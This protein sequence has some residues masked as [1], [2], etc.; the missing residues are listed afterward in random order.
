MN[1]LDVLPGKWESERRRIL[2]FRI[3]IIYRFQKDGKAY[4]TIKF[5]NWIYQAAWSAI[6][7]EWYADWGLASERGKIKLSPRGGTSYPT[8]LIDQFLRTIGIRI[9]Y[10]EFISSVARIGWNL[11]GQGDNATADIEIIDNN[12]FKLGKVNMRRIN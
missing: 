3:N 6:D 9:S 11:V 1:T 10:E 4:F 7:A 8:R 2:G 12:N 5:K